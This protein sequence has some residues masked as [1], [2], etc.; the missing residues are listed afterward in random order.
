MAGTHA[1]LSPSKSAMF[2]TCAA[3]L[4]VAKGIP[5]KSS[6]FAAEGTAYHE[7][8]A[9][10]L[11]TGRDCSDRIGEKFTVVETDATYDFVIDEDGAAHAQVY[12]DAIRRLPG[13]LMV[14]VKLDLSPVYGVEGQT[15]TGDAV[16]L[17]YDSRTIYVCDL[18]FGRGELVEA[19]GNTQL[20]SY[21][22]AALTLAELMG[23]WDRVVMQ[24]HQPRIGHFDEETL[25][26]AE[27]RAWEESI[28]LP[29]QRA[30]SIYETGIALPGDFKP[31][32]KACRWCP[33]SG[34]CAAQARQVVDD[35]PIV[36][37]A[38]KPAAVDL[39]DT[40]LGA[41]R[42]RVDALE[43]YCAAIKAEAMKRAMDGKHIP[44]WKLVDGRLGNR[45]WKDEGVVET[46]LQGAVGEEAYQPAKLISPADAEKLLTKKKHVLVPAEVRG[47]AWEALQAQIDRAP[48]SK[49]LVRESAPGV[50]VKPN[51]PDEFPLVSA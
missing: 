24:I 29:A 47:A 37:G 51:S 23:T 49:N 40:A 39:D 19:K 38:V 28:R 45:K 25:T 32:P 41:A 13:T 5:N 20:R 22:A 31:S 7:L 11:E 18:K 6:R 1:V 27:L 10:A 30:Y 16:V 17:D 14:E 44:G 43:D 2:L 48:A 3:S 12:V 42:D 46:V 33:K 15:G 9:W 34:N 8:A 36:D 35:F 4:A 50:P 21:G 26:V